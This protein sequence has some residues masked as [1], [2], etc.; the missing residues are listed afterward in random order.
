MN[1]L[2]VVHEENKAD[3]YLIEIERPNIFKLKAD[4]ILGVVR[5]KEPFF[6]SYS[7]LDYINKTKNLSYDL[8]IEIDERNKEIL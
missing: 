3:H 2:V 1:V 8:M 6:S 7:Y 5:E 4:E